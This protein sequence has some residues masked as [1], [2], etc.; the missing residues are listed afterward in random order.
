M[1]LKTLKEAK[2]KAGS[3]DGGA[4]ITTVRT[5]DRERPRSRMSLAVIDRRATICGVSKIWRSVPRRKLIEGVR[6]LTASGQRLLETV[7][8]CRQEQYCEGPNPMSVA[9][10]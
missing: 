8:A 5:V 3:T 10:M 9:G 1:H 2:S 4:E 6:S 7:T